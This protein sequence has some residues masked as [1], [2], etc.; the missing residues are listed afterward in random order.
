MFMGHELIGLLVVSICRLVLHVF[1]L[2]IFYV[3]VLFLVLVF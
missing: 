3:A 2:Y 1:V